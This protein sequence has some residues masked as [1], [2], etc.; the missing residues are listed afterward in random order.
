M[1]VLAVLAVLV[2]LAVVC[3]ASPVLYL[4]PGICIFVATGCKNIA[5]MLPLLLRLACKY[6][7]TALLERPDYGIA[8]K[9]IRRSAT[10]GTQTKVNPLPSSSASPSPSPCTAPAVTW[11]AIW[12][13]L[14]PRCG[15]PLWL[16][17]GI[18]NKCR[19]SSADRHSPHRALSTTFH[20]MGCHATAL[21]STPRSI[22]PSATN[23]ICVRYFLRV[24]WVP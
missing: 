13:E 7:L 19:S 17:C 1:A 22:Q 11:T 5:G 9:T 18:S 3:V 15:L 6:N 8:R 23:V 12:H 24:A 2:V 20:T 4:L 14:K 10:T 21:L 16:S